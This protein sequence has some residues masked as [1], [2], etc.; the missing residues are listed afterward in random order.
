MRRSRSPRRFLTA[1]LAYV[2]ALQALVAAL[3]AI[4]QAPAADLQAVICAGDGGSGP[5]KTGH[6]S[7][8]SC[9]LAGGCCAATA[10][11]RDGNAA[12]AAPVDHLISHSVIASAA[13]AIWPSE[14]PRLVTR[15]TGAD[16]LNLFAYAKVWTH[17]A[18]AARQLR[19]SQQDQ[20]Q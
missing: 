8:G 11:L 7:D 13:P 9:C 2:V 12:A 10:I 16:V 14:R 1:I 3:V 15:A 18:R 4:P 17:C 6:E 20:H 19:T 5:V